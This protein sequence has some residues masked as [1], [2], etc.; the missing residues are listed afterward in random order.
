M[1][2]TKKWTDKCCHAHCKTCR[3]A[4]TGFQF[5]CDISKSFLLPENN[6][7]FVCPHGEEWTEEYKLPFYEVDRATIE[8]LSTERILSLEELEVI[9]K[10]LGNPEYLIMKFQT[11]KWVIE[12]AEC[13]SCVS[14]SRR[15]ALLNDIYTWRTMNK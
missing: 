3:A 4:I 6:V 5:R 14:V 9:I 2:N 15:K 8:K 12:G 13:T 1:N 7:N 10:D 11:V